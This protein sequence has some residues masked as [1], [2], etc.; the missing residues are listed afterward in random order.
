MGKLTSAQRNLLKRIERAAKGELRF[1]LPTYVM[2]G[3]MRDLGLVDIIDAP[4][5]T[6]W[7]WSGW[8]ITITPAGRSALADKG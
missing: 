6:G 5:R 4:G 7:P 1:P 2:A 3:R 8:H